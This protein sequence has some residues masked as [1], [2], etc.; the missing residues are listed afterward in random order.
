MS[1][2]QELIRYNKGFV[3]NPP[4]QVVEE[5]ESITKLPSRE[6][7]ILTCMDTRLVNFLEDALG[8]NR[9][10]AKVLKTAGN[11]ITGPFDGVVR[12]LLVCIYE[13]GVKELFVIGHYECGMVKTTADS[14]TEKMRARGVSQ[15][16]IFMV[17]KEMEHWADGFQ[18]P[19]SNVVETVELLRHNPLIP[20][21]VPVHGLMLHP[22]SGEMDVVVDG[23]RYITTEV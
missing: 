12:S 10:E 7:A 11:C 19:V 21:D 5:S 16:A 2:L 23:Y 4:Q 9:G 15:D 1:L 20:K 3:E 17:Q 8:I 18:H 6:I 13:L 14:L 22:H